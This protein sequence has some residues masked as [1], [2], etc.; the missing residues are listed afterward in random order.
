VEPD[1][2]RMGGSTVDAGDEQIRP[3]VRG[4]GLEVILSHGA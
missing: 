3:V 2:E 1:I 4:A